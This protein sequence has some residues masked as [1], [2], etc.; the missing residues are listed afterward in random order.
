MNRITRN[1]SII[2]RSER[3]IA[4]RHMALLR[5]QTGLFA[6][7]GLVA[8]LGIIMLNMAGYL[9]LAGVM[10]KPMA[11][12]IVAGVNIAVAG[13]L[14]VIAGRST[15]DAET[16][17]VAEVRDLALEDLEAELQVALD[18]V[19]QVADG[20]RRVGRD[21]LGQIAPGLVAALTKA[22]IKNLKS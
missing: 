6:A 3:L 17:P 14:A 15:A 8:G 11:A 1:L 16:A 13:L 22:L 5:R 10:S 20:I 12:L 7:A 9:A 21:P 4:Q 19:K 18:E 2:L